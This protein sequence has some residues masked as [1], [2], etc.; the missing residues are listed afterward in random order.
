MALPKHAAQPADTLGIPATVVSLP[1]LEDA[2]SKVAITGETSPVAITGETSPTG[3][4]VVTYA[5]L[6]EERRFFIRNL[7]MHFK[8]Q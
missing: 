4:V 2:Q 7:A 5:A 1:S 6:E 3:S 8:P